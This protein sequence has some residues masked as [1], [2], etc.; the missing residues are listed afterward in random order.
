MK[1]KIIL[2]LCI[3]LLTLGVS[4][5]V[6]SENKINVRQ[7]IVKKPTIYLDYLCQNSDM[8]FLRMYNNTEWHISVSSDIYFPTRKSI[9]LRNGVKTSAAPNDEAISS[10]FYFVSPDGLAFVRKVKVPKSAREGVGNDGGGAWIAP[11]DSIFFPVPQ[12]YLRKGL[13]VS[14]QFEYEWE[15][16]KDGV[17]SNEPEHKVYFRGAKIPIKKVKCDQK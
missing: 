8:I 3:F 10:L 15:I 11:N 9:T 4:S 16:G 6:S 14:V 5:Q 7:A 17:R 13:R 2:V 12:K 1:T